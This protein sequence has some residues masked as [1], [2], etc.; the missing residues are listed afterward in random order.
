MIN[1][2]FRLSFPEFSNVQSYPDGML[3]LWGGMAEQLVSIDRF[4]DM[5]DQMVH[6]AAAH[7]VSLAQQNIK[8]KGNAGL[9]Q[10]SKSVGAVSVS[11]DTGSI[12]S[13]GAGQWNATS[14]GR[15]YLQ[16]CRLFGVGAVNV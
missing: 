16:M 15:L 5:R 14:Y 3:N 7:L 4:G 1:T 6:T 2:D 8:K 9:L 11:Q 10:T 13:A 12:V